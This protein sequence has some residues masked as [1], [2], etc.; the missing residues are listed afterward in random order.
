[1]TLVETNE[2]IDQFRATLSA[3]PSNFPSTY[4]IGITNIFGPGATG[5]VVPQVG[6][7]WV[8]YEYGNVPAKLIQVWHQ[9]GRRTPV[10]LGANQIPVGQGDILVYQLANPA[11]DTIKLGYQ[12]V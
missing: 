4:W 1:M 3:T 10:N 5:I 9:G 2:Q 11:T 6:T 8:F 7:L 12:M